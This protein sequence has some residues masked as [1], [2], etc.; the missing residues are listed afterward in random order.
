MGPSGAKAV[1]PAGALSAPTLIAI[2]QTSAG[3]PALPT[4]VVPF[5]PIFAF[6]PHGT[7]F[8]V[9]VEITVPFD[10]TLVPPGT[11]PVLYKTNPAMT[12]WGTVASATTSGG[13]MTGSVRGFSFPFVGP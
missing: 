2:T 11:Q 12:G 13:T 5:G 3:A 4:G 7:T 1:I 9:P 6:T 10:P 8:A